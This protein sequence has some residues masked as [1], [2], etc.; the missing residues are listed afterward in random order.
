M[1]AKFAIGTCILLQGFPWKVF[2]V[3]KDVYGTSYSVYYRKS[4][5]DYTKITLNPVE[6]RDYWKR[7]YVDSAATPVKCEKVGLK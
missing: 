5:S 4:N 2:L 1:I 6:A 7:E 3:T